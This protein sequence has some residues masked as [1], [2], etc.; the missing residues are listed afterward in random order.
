[1]KIALVS[2][3]DFAHTGGVTN[4]ISALDHEYTQIGHDVRIIAPASK[5][6]TD[7][8]DRF[9]P[10]GRP[11]PIP[12]SESIIRVPISL[13]LA[14]AIKEVVAREKFELVHLHEPFMPMLCSA[15]L[16]FS[17]AVNVG[18]FHA[19]EGKPG[20]NWGRPIS[21]WMIRQRLHKLHGKI[22]VSQ[23]ALAYHSRYI[24]GP[25]EIIPNGVDLEHFTDD[26]APFEEYLDGKKTILFLSRLEFRKG[27]NY[28]LNAFLLVKREMPDVRLIVVG[29]GTR[30]RRRY[31]RWVRKTGLEKDVIFVG[32]APEE[33]KPRY[34]KTADIFSVPA[35][36][37]ES[38]GLI[39]LEAM[40]MGT[41]VVAT[42]IAG[43]ASVVTHGEDGLLVPPRNYQEL[44]QAL[45]TLLEDEKLRQQMGEKGKAKAKDYD[46]KV[47]S[48]KLLD[49]YQRTID[50]VRGSGSQ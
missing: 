20:Y 27:L 2:P 10:I 29:A 14:P 13:H 28:L 9:I 50:R 22:V 6:I 35:T 42:S 41:P 31:E 40:A 12:S 32:F 16:R 49:F 37:R 45:L 1:M 11:W 15:V 19:A 43:Y 38:Q 36:G 25:F 8:G 44:S 23:A 24:P 4:H 26:V 47:V 34:Y 33:D 3:Y 7:F 39:L 48:R 21:T 18:T 30:L 5:P 17:D 46:W